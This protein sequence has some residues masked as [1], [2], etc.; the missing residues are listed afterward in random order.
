MRH[1][2]NYRTTTK[3]VLMPHHEIIRQILVLRVH[4]SHGLVNCPKATPCR[5]PPWHEEMTSMQGFAAVNKPPRGSGLQGRPGHGPVG[6]GP[7]SF[8]RPSNP[9]SSSSVQKFATSHPLLSIRAPASLA[10]APLAAAPAQSS[11]R[12]DTSVCFDVE[13]SCSPNMLL[14]DVSTVTIRRMLCQRLPHRLTE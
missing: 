7:G 4:P 9:P 13:V 11:R 1:A 6:R 10:E 12:C 5:S 2:P 14:F 8:L 3:A